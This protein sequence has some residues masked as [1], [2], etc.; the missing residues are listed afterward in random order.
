MARGAH[1]IARFLSSLCGVDLTHG[2]RGP[3]RV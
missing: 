3:V 2:A 1:T